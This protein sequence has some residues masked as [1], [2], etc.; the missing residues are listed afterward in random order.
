MAPPLTAQNLQPLRDPP[1]SQLEEWRRESENH[2][3]LAIGKQPL[4]PSKTQRQ[5]RL[6]EFQ[7][8]IESGRE[9]DLEASGLDPE[10]EGPPKNLGHC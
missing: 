1:R 8:K 10:C 3:Q 7:S 5:T 6:D 9:P 4:R 2:E